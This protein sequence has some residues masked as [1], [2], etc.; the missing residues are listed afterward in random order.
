[1]LPT[2]RYK[3]LR[4][5]MPPEFLLLP[6]LQNPKSTSWRFKPEQKLVVLVRSVACHHEDIWYEHFVSSSML[7]GLFQGA[8][9]NLL[10]LGLQF[11]FISRGILTKIV[12]PIL[13][14]I[15]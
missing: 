1:M 7:W 4:P 13:M 2:L 15:K 5:H 6:E 8:S 10:K 12:L 11:E 14:T 9:C 3:Q